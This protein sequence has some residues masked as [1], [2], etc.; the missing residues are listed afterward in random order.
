[1]K[2]ELRMLIFLTLTLTVLQGYGQVVK[3]CD[4][5][6]LLETSKRVGTLNQKEITDFLLTLGHQCRDSI[7]FSE[8]SNELLFNILDKQTELTLT[9]LDKKQGEMET[10]TILG[11]LNSPI[12]DNV[13]ILSL[14]DKIE[15]VTF[16]DIL[17][18]QIITHLTLANN[19]D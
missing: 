19:K 7:E 17:K 12:T 11:I 15:K 5:K 16:N 4:S 13:N 1:M 8:W 14:I 18:S 10:K 2:F 9:T 3:K 6:V